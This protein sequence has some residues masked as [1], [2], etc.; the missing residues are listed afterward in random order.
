MDSSCCEIYHCQHQH[1]LFL[2]SKWPFYYGYYTG[3]FFTGPPPKKLKYGNSRLGE[4]TCIK[5]V[6]LDTPNLA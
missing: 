2:I 6:I 3:C 1:Q 4:V 5:D